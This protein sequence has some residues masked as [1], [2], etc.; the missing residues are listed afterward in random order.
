MYFQVQ[1]HDC[2]WHRLEGEDE[3]SLSSF[4]I[5]VCHYFE[6]RIK[7]LIICHKSQAKIIH[8]KNLM[9]NLICQILQALNYWQ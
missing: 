9:P 3:L 8:V 7:V 1:Q 6:Q 2:R 5:L 4:A